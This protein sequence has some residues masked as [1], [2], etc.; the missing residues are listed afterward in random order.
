MSEKSPEEVIMYDVKGLRYL[1]LRLLVPT[2]IVFPSKQFNIN[3]GK[4]VFLGSIAATF[5]LFTASYLTPSSWTFL[6]YADAIVQGTKLYFPERP[7]VAARDIGFPLIILL[8]GYTITR[9]IIPLTLIHAAF[10]V[11]IPI[12][13]Y[14][15]LSKFSNAVAFYAGC[16]TLMSLTPFLFMKWI[17]HDQTYIFFMM[18][19]IALL[20]RYLQTLRIPYLYAFTTAA[21]TASLARPAGNL[22]VPIF[23]SVAYAYERKRLLHYVT[24]AMIMLGSAALYQWH[25]H[26]IFAVPD[27]VPRQS[28]TGQQIFYGL[29]INSA[30]FGVALSPELASQHGPDHPCGGSRS[31]AEP[32]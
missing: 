7:G 25:R 17:H 3:V 30:E 19:M 1:G 2:T 28:Y 9:S 18:L 32:S 16:A 27:G 23:L 22:L 14:V 6:A 29:Y 24:C 26:E 13:V 15:S 5:F 8:S 4:L 21:I 31:C 20:L 11:M 10:A 12:F